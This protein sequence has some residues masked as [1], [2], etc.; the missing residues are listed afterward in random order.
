MGVCL[1]LHLNKHFRCE[2]S[3]DNRRCSSTGYRKKW[4]C[5]NAI[6][7]NENEELYRAVFRVCYFYYLCD[8]SYIHRPFLSAPVPEKH[9]G[10]GTAPALGSV[11][12]K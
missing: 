12:Q 6:F 3:A 2:K 5:K 8:F 4:L 1:R 11:N 9:D 7:S 10:P